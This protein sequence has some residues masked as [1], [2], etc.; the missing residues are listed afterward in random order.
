MEVG[1]EGYTQHNDSIYDRSNHGGNKSIVYSRR[2]ES[3]L[4]MSNSMTSSLVIKEYIDAQEN[5]TYNGQMK[6]C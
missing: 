5:A 6:K 2:T 3:N 4:P 1:N